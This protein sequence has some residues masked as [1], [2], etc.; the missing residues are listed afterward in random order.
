[1]TYPRPIPNDS[2]F[3]D[4]IAAIETAPDL[5]RFVVFATRADYHALR[6]DL[7]HVSH[8]RYLRSM[9]ASIAVARQR[10]FP[11]VV[12]ELRA[13]AFRL[14]QQRNG[15]SGPDE[16]HVSLYSNFASTLRDPAI[17]RCL[18]LTSATPDDAGQ[19]SQPADAGSAAPELVESVEKNA[20]KLLRLHQRRSLVDVLMVIFALELTATSA[21]VAEAAEQLAR[22]VATGVPRQFVTQ[23]RHAAFLM[24]AQGRTTSWGLN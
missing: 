19:V 3:A 17:L 23:A 14:W 10:G 8:A 4:R 22:R 16:H 21:A 1:M 18:G 2:A 6:P 9:A 15:L 13:D 5:L 11:L 24:A 20:I 12:K 7:R